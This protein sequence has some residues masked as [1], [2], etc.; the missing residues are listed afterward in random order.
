MIILTSDLK[1]IDKIWY[2]FIIKDC[3][4]RAEYYYIW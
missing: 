3:Q 2:L 4:Q 1:V